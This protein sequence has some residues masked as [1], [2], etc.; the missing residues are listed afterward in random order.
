MYYPQTRSNE[1]HTVSYKGTTG[2]SVDRL[3]KGNGWKKCL[4]RL[5]CS[6]N[7]LLRRV[8]GYEGFAALIPAEPQLSSATKL[9]QKDTG[10]RY[11]EQESARWSLFVSLKELK[12]YEFRSEVSLTRHNSSQQHQDLWKLWKKLCFPPGLAK[13]N[14]HSTEKSSQFLETLA[15]SKLWL[16]TVAPPRSLS[17]RQ[18]K[19]ILG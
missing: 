7:P 19:S 2:N 14:F 6:K 18:E 12:S 5:S 9:Q 16:G 8:L 10:K 3:S 13:W 15:A 4:T 11:W 1:K 17:E